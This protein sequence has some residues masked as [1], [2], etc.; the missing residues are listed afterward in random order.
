VRVCLDGKETSR[1]TRNHPGVNL[2]GRKAV[3]GF[4]PLPGEGLSLPG[5]EKKEAPWPIRS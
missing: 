5:R 2:A 3:A 1:Y 4:Q